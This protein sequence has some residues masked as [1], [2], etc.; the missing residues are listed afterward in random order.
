MSFRPVAVV[1]GAGGLGTAIADRVGSGHELLLA[2]V[3]L[4]RADAAAERL[5]IGGHSVSTMTCD[6]SSPDAVADLSAAA[7][8]LGPVVKLV[9]TAGVSPGQAPIDRIMAINLLGTALILD[10]FGAIVA[11]GGVGVCISSM[12]GHM[13]GLDADLQQELAACPTDRLLTVRGVR[14][15]AI[16]DTVEAYCIAKRANQLR[17]AAAAIGAW[18]RRHAR[19]NTISPGIIAT[20]MSAASLATDEGDRMRQMIVDSPAQRIGT[21]A[22][23]AAAAAFLLSPEASFITGTDLLVDGGATPAMT[24]PAS[25][26]E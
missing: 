21:P 2:D 26:Q 7:E 9:H 20:D 18:G 4:A 22:E 17:V 6:V 14:P 11:P 3:D 10:A 12:A 23:L 24:L 8:R 5:R 25:P 13:P 16:S 19:I 15:D 1:T